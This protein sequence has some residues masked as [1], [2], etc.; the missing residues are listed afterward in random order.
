MAL[1]GMPMYLLYEI[2]ILLAGFIERKR[3]RDEAALAAK[4]S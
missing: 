2:C 1:M 4:S 3:L